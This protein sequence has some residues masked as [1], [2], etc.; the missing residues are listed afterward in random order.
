MQQV[1][2][3]L[4]PEGARSPRTLPG[5]SFLPATLAQP[6]PADIPSAAAQT[7]RQ[8]AIGPPYI[9][10]GTSIPDAAVHGGPRLVPRVHQMPTLS[11]RGRLGRGSRVWQPSPWPSSSTCTVVWEMPRRRQADVTAPCTAC[12]SAPSRRVTWAASSGIPGFRLQMC[13]SDTSP[14]PSTSMSARSTRSTSKCRGTR[15][16]RMSLMSCRMRRVVNS[17][18][19]AN[20][21]VQI[22]SAI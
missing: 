11:S 13:R 20:T 21:K 8:C 16:I 4:P 3:C 2:R 12:A 18:R 15:S 6:Q 7:E 22:G 9:L 17:T 1:P 5:G 10:H 14:T 19:S